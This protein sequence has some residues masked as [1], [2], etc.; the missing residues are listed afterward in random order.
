M[1]RFVV[2][3]LCSCLFAVASGT[4][5]FAAGDQQPGVSVSSAEYR[6]MDWKVKLELMREMVARFHQNKC[7]VALKPEDLM[8]IVDADLGANWNEESAGVSMGSWVAR[9]LQLDEAKC[10]DGAQ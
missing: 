7:A 2:I 3:L 1:M 6:D 8:R 5:A 10:V 9:L 4:G